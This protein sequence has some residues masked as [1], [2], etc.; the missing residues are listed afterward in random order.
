[1]SDFHRNF[2]KQSFWPAMSYLDILDAIDER[3]NVKEPNWKWFDHEEIH[4]LTNLLRHALINDGV[5]TRH[6]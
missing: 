5:G 4:E 1:M 3:V 6:Y 2:Q